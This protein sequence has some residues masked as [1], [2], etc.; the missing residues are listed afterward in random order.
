M[1][2][3]WISDAVFASFTMTDKFTLSTLLI[4]PDVEAK[5]ICVHGKV[6]IA[7]SEDKL[8]IMPF[9]YRVIADTDTDAASVVCDELRKLY[10]P[11]EQEAA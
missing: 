1:Y 3:I 6:F 4:H 5:L 8:A 7:K 2:D 11:Q 9:S 10:N